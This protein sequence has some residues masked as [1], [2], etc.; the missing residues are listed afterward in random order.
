M[1]RPEASL[2][3]SGL[4]E[5]E[6]VLGRLQQPNLDRAAQRVL[7]AAAR[8]LVVP[9]RQATDFQGHG[10]VPGRLRKSVKARK[11]RPGKP[12]PAAVVGPTSPYR[13]LVIRGHRIVAHSTTGVRATTVI[14]RRG[15]RD[16]GAMSRANPFVDRGIAGQEERVKVFVER[17]LARELKL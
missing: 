11:G 5:A 4:A 8:S 9:I 16:T 1:A 3:V 14:N 12:L 10:K 6:K 13:H 7:L 2:Q 17:Q 15:L